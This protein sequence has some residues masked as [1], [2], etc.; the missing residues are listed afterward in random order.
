MRTV[1]RNL[2][3]SGILIGAV[4]APIPAQSGPNRQERKGKEK[5][6][7]VVADENE[8]GKTGPGNS[9]SNPGPAKGEKR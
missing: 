2:V 8:K 3:L 7:A 1:F 9:G 5:V 4:T 6:Q